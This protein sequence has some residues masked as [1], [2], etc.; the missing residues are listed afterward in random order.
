MRDNASMP[1]VSVVTVTL[2]CARTLEHTLLAT[3]RQDYSNIEIIII[4]GGSTDGTID[5]IRSYD[6]EIDLWISSEDAGPYDAMNKAAQLANG[7]FCLFMNAGDWFVGRHAV[8]KAIEDVPQAADFIIGHHIYRLIDGTDD[9]HKANAFDQTWD[10]LRRGELSW[11]W[12]HGVPCHQ[13]TFT[14]TRLLRE[15]RYDLRYR[16]AADHEFMYRQRLNG[17]YFHHCDDVIALYSS[18]GLSWNNQIRCLQE[19]LE[20][21]RRYGPPEAAE[22]MFRPAIRSAIRGSNE[23]AASATATALRTLVGRWRFTARAAAQGRAN[24]GWVAANLDP[25][26]HLLARRLRHS[27]LFSEQWYVDT[28]PDIRNSNTDPIVHYLREGA[29]ELRDPSPFFDTSYYREMNPDV[30]ASGIN[31]L[32]HYLERGAVEGRPPSSWFDRATFIASAHVSGGTRSLPTLIEWL[33][34]QPAEDLVENWP[35]APQP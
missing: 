25:K 1:L 26:T 28:Y 21:A 23:R 35:G 24:L 14:R 20:I 19:L 15:E 7:R 34:T 9:L 31:P 5:V 29:D 30:A 13:A 27:G 17:A 16:I 3:L 12:L 11:L 22:R 10:V 18:G 6:A 32:V 8:S 4:D 2:N 33:A